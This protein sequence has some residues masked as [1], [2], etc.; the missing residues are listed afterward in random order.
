MTILDRAID[1]KRRAQ[2][3][4]QSGDL[5]GAL[6]EYE[7]LIAADES[8]PYNY[9][10]LADLLYKKGDHENASRRYLYAACAYEKNGIYKNA[11]AVGKKMMRHGL[12]AATVLER[13][14]NLHSL[15][16]LA[17]EATLYYQQYA[18]HQVRE[19][20]TREAADALRKAYDC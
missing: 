12:S 7:K 10:L 17:T 5:D 1:I 9:V 8:D 11:I 2:R 20:R 6:A 14:G 18:E 19:N 4:I 13:L 16:G 15:D 3:C